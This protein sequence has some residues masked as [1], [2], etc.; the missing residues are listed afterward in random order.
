[1]AVYKNCALVLVASVSGK[2]YRRKVEIFLVGLLS[3]RS[4]FYRS[5]KGLELIAEPLSHANNIRSASILGGDGGNGH[6]LAKTLD[7]V[8]GRAVDLLEETVELRSH[9][10]CLMRTNRVCEIVPGGKVEFG[11]KSLRDGSS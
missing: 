3:K 1:M 7:E 8:V 6:S 5:S 2:D 11:R 4:K 10:L 9:L